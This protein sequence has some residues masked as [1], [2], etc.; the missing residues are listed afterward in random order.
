MS[1]LDSHAVGSEFDAL[2]SLE[3]WIGRVELGPRGRNFGMDLFSGGIFSPHLGCVFFF[4]GAGGG[5]R[6]ESFSGRP[7]ENQSHGWE[8]WPGTVV[9]SVVLTPRAK[10]RGRVMCKPLKKLLV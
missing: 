4:S 2:R 1:F 9:E 5:E 6:L 8:M 10:L 3:D 7:K